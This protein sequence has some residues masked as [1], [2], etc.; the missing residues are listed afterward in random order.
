MYVR[1]V[2]GKSFAMV[3]VYVTR[4]LSNSAFLQYNAELADLSGISYPTTHGV[5]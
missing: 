4:L 1:R 2:Y 5:E 3:K